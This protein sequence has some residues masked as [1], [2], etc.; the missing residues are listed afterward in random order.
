MEHH[1]IASGVHHRSD[2]C[3]EEPPTLTKE[4]TIP[5]DYPVDIVV[6]D[7]VSWEASI[8]GEK[9]VEIP[10]QNIILPFPSREIRKDDHCV[11]IDY[12]VNNLMPQ[13][14]NRDSLEAVFPDES[15]AGIS[16]SWKKRWMS[17]HEL[18]ME[19]SS[20]RTNVRVRKEIASH[21]GIR[22]TIF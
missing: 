5:V 2:I 11:Q 20:F 19:K 13:T 6:R 4:S 10:T 8:V 17:C 12:I 18:H 3:S 7:G 15:S 22:T 21:I 14:L 9:G 1:E 16:S